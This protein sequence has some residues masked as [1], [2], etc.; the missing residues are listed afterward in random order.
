MYKYIIYIERERQGDQGRA[1]TQ[2]VHVLGG[3]GVHHPFLCLNQA[4]AGRAQGSSG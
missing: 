2:R 1:A 4:S 3:G